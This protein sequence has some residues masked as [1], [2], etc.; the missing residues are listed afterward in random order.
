VTARDRARLLGHG[1]GITAGNL[2]NFALD[3]I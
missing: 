1:L 3:T 2:A